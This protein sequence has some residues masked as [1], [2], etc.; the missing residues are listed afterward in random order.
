MTERNVHLRFKILVCVFF[1]CLFLKK[2]N[3]FIQQGCKILLCHHRN[4][5]PSKKNIYIYI[6]I[7]SIYFHRIR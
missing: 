3:D 6:Y 7:S 2:K 1:V 4:K 5:L